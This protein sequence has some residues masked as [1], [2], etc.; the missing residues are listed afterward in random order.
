M[1][2]RAVGVSLAALF[3]ATLGSGGLR[4][5]QDQKPVFRSS[6][7]LVTIPVF[8]SGNGGQVAGLTASD[9]VLTDNG[10][11]Q[12][13]ETIDSESLPVD[14]TVLVETSRALAG[15]ADS[16]NEQIHRIAALVRPADR[17]EVLG[18][19]NYVSV[20][21]PF[22]PASRPFSVDRFTGGGLTSVNDAMAGALVR[23][24]DPDRRHLIIALTDSVD[25]MST[26][27]L[28]VVRDVARQASAT[29]V[30]AWISLSED[31]AFVPPP[32][33]PTKAPPWATSAE[34]ADRHVRLASE[35][36]VPARQQWTPHIEPPPGRTIYAFDALKEAAE[37]T[38]GAMHPPGVMVDRSASV[39]FDK[40]YAEFRRNYLLR[41]L[42][43]GVT[44]DGWHD[45][46]VT[47]PKFPNLDI[48]A[49]RGYLVEATM[50]P[51][52]PAPAPAAGTIE[53]LDSAMSRG[54]LTELRRAIA[55][56]DSPALATLI[57]TF[58]ERAVPAGDPRREF[59]AA[60][61]LAEAAVASPTADLHRDAVTLLAPYGR[62]VRLPTGTSAFEHD[63]LVAETAL[64]EAA[65]RPA[66]ALP[67]VRTALT[68][69]PDDPQLLLARAVL[70]DQLTS[71]SPADGG[72]PLTP[73]A[74]D[75]L[76]GFYDAAIAHGE[77][78]QEARIR[79][80]W[81]LKRVDRETDAA[82]TL[83]SVD[84]GADPMLAA[85]R[86]LIQTQPPM[87]EPVMDESRWLE[88][89]RANHRSFPAL[90]DRV[91]HDDWMPAR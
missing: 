83:A 1:T 22:G 68:R 34:R 37:G 9:F 47:I 64:L 23:E 45:V 33:D 85:W 56:A 7:D 46:K 65:L 69:F 48:R 89:W 82:Q 61:A 29:L 17:L 50:P 14:V 78:A 24:P 62:L 58:H 30:V 71:I 81:L 6:T 79:R 19:D 2:T 43:R 25:S 18:I 87:T 12:A 36:T 73:R 35:R 54:D 72:V 63:W 84:A 39:I 26:L 88:F 74:R 13:V 42:P 27:T 75:E 55:G 59:V 51:R 3:V 52:P 76:F 40:I 91:S 21:L 80:A 32:D 4:G 11:P 20:L 57:H 38:G 10:V 41:F 70:A 90:L 44:R 60:L 15:Y 77:T 8:V 66:D 5:G 31:P 86:D 67:L 53:A 49:R 28:P 16:I